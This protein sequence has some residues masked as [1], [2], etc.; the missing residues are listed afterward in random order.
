M[1]R[2]PNE[3]IVLLLGNS[4]SLSLLILYVSSSVVSD[5]R[6]SPAF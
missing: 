6:A 5:V 3:F 2:P 4:P 1:L